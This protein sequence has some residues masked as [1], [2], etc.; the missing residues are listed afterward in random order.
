MRHRAELLGGALVWELADGR[1]RVEMTLPA[2][3][4]RVKR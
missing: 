4:A 1:F 2:E 3:P